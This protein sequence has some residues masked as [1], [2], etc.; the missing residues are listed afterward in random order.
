M[1]G[2][3]S[4]GTQHISGLFARVSKAIRNGGGTLYGRF[5]YSASKME[6]DHKAVMLLHSIYE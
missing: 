2:Y 1:A 3:E 4:V 6:T 5:A